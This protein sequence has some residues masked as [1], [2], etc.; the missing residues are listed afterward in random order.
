MRRDISNRWAIGLAAL[1]VLAAACKSGDQGSNSTAPTGNAGETSMPGGGDGTG[2]DANTPG[3]GG[4]GTVA[5]GGTGT[6]DMPGVGGGENAPGSWDNS[7]WDD[8]LWQ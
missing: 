2:G 7:T 1:C 3:F 8:A 5:M 6:G 4:D